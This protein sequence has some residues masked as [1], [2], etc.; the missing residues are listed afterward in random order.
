MR[1][2]LRAQFVLI[3]VLTILAA[4]ALAPFPGKERIP[5]LSQCRIRPGMDLAGGAELRYRVLFPEGFQGDPQGS[6]SLAAEVVRRRVDATLLEESKVSSHGKDGLVVQLPG[7]DANGLEACKRRLE[8][9]GELRLYASAPVDVQERYDRDRA[10][11]AGYVVLRDRDQRTY[12]VEANPVIEG[13]HVVH[14]E[15]QLE[16]AD[17]APRW[18]TS[19]E[20]D[21]EGARLFDEAA[22]TLY[23]RRPP[24]R[25][26]IVLDGRVQ[27]AP[28]VR[29]S[30]FHGRGQIR[31][32]T[33]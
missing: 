31:G 15:P 16:S 29:S 24:G 19:F 20:L 3:L 27:S 21:A 18:A 33:P 32:G 25:I 28:L 17:G 10:V 23:N 5:V 4:A 9:M 1:R 14:A 13:R 11:P 6:T 8:K 30:T 22:A 7:A 12:L 2:F 26:V